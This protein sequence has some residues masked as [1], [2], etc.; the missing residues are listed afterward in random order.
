MKMYS[1]NN[2]SDLKIVKILESAQRSLM[3][4]G[5]ELLIEY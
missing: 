2:L 5:L 3:N 4:G 1:H